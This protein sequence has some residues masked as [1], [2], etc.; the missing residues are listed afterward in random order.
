MEREAEVAILGG[1]TARVSTAYKLASWGKIEEQPVQLFK[2]Y[3]K[4]GSSFDPY[5]KLSKCIS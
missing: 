3:V 2:M 1:G 4:N 5:L